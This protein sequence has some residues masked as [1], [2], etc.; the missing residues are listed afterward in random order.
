MTNTKIKTPIIE[1]TGASE[2]KRS[3]SEE[4]MEQ[5]IPKHVEVEPEVSNPEIAENSY[6]NPNFVL[7]YPC[8]ECLNPVLTKKDLYKAKHNPKH[9]KEALGKTIEIIGVTTHS[10][11]RQGEPRILTTIICKDGENY[12]SSAVTMATKMLDLVDAFGD[13]I[14]E[15]S[16]PCKITQQETR[17]DKKVYSI[18]LV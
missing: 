8:F 7:N 12:Y 3:I 18:E 16:L 15:T 11:K 17:D 9:F 1:P 13:D 14:K 6:S 4:A 5:H 2:I 10:I